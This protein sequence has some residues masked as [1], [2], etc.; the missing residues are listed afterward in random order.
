MDLS[1]TP[2]FQKS[3][4]QQRAAK[5]DA[6]EEEKARKAAEIAK[7]AGYVTGSEA[8]KLFNSVN[9]I[10]MYK[11]REFTKYLLYIDIRKNYYQGE[12]I[13][14]VRICSQIRFRIFN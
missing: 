2:T 13:K 8:K 9:I 7:Q 12:R 1:K 3:I 4:E 10:I 5:R 6:E 14:K 11:L